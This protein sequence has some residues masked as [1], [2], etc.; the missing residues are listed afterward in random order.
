MT[1]YRATYETRAGHE[2]RMTFAAADGQQ[3]QRV[4]TE[5]ELSDDKLRRVVP[6]RALERPLLVLD[7]RGA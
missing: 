5:W 3:A 4:A 6:L 1:L 7:G 2:R